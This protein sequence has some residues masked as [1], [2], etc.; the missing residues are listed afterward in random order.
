MNGIDRHIDIIDL[1]SMI[2]RDYGNPA[3]WDQ[4]YEQRPQQFDWYF[5]WEEF[6]KDNYSKL[7]LQIPILEVGCGNSNL[8][9]HLTELGY[10]PIISMDVSKVVISQMHLKYP[11]L[12]FCPM[13]VRKMNFRNESFSCVIDK[14]TLD[15][16][17]CGHEFYQAVS[18]ML[19]EIGRILAPGGTFIE[20]TFAQDRLKFLDSPDILPWTLEQQFEFQNDIG[21]VYIFQFRKFKEYIY[22]IHASNQLEQIWSSSSESEDDSFSE[23]KSH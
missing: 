17:F 5:E 1:K 4:T 2:Q 10:G 19:T 12:C 8:S 15:A 22:D 6:L 3:Y 16:L 13:D 20:I 14:G 11:N 21:T 23:G 18:K 9:H 7:N